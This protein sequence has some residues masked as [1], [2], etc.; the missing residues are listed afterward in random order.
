MPLYLVETPTE[1]RLVQANN[2]A[3]AI[4]FAVKSTVKARSLTGDDIAELID[5]GF[6][7]EKASAPPEA[8]EPETK[9][10]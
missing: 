6:K 9:P 10:D 2:Q 8:K 3:V 1:K 7:I 5:Q 4:N